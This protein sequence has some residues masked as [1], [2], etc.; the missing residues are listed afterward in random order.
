MISGFSLPVVKDVS[1]AIFQHCPYSI[2]K[3]QT[4]LDLS[5]SPSLVSIYKCTMP[6]E[7]SRA[8]AGFAKWF[9]P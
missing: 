3:T 6:L 4:K 1:T 8:R 9:I 2:E 7:A 5:D